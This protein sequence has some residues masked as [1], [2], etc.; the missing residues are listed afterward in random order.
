M[1]FL[2]IG[3]NYGP[4]GIGIA[5]YTQGLAEALI[6]RGH[7][8]RVI[9]GKPY[10]PEWRVRAG[11]NGSWRRTT[12][13]GVDITRCPIYVPAKPSGARRIAHLLSFSLSALFPALS[14]A[15]NFDPDLVLVIAP[16]LLSAPV[17]RVAA[18][19][20]GAKSWLHI[21]DFELE[22]AFATGLLGSQSFMTKRAADFERTTLRGFD[23]VSS[24][25]PEMCRKLE[26]Y[27]IPRDRI[28]EFRN[29]AEIDLVRPL[30]GPST[31]RA[32]WNI[33]T[34]HVA[35][36]S[37]NIANKQGIDIIIDA[38]RLLHGRTDLTFVICGEGPNRAAVEALAAGLNNVVFQDLQP[39]DRLGE[40]L[41]LAT[42]HLLPQRADA[43]DLMLP[44]KLTNMLASGRPVVVTAA[45]NSGL[46]REVEGCGIA[47]PPDD[48]RAFATAIETII[49]M[50]D[51]Y[52]E[53]CRASRKRAT[54][55]WN[56][57]AI[58]GR[59]EARA[60]QLCQRTARS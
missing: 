53:L 2:I 4:D 54:D 11:H 12:E 37:G 26:T 1:R 10:Y 9:A 18:R 44:S 23:V 41:G 35:L 52:E 31:Y 27:G 49:D 32:A 58:V 7:E 45:G 30:A 50:G 51:E 33:K 22:A 34:R 25:S 6:A 43:A 28:H 16:S 15:R 21:Q 46:A 29:W 19:L 59:F 38:A 42:V 24:I 48:Q 40:L 20:A 3:L 55:V 17:A 13:R 60:L 47:T 39:L 36:Y 14:A 5:P 8:V 57:E 56:R